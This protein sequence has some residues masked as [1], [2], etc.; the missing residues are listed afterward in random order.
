MKTAQQQERERVWAGGV[1]TESQ[2]ISLGK[3]AKS[4][5]KAML[6]NPSVMP[7][8]LADSLVNAGVARFELNGGIVVPTEYGLELVSA[9][10]IEGR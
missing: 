5:Q 4:P 9:H 2:W 3:L 6:V 1:I 10:G 7:A 8:Y